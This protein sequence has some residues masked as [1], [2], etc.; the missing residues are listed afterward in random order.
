M[1]PV[2]VATPTNHDFGLVHC[3]STLSSVSTNK[4]TLRIKLGNISGAHAPW[5]LLHIPR[6]KKSKTRSAMDP[7][8]L[9]NFTNPEF[10]EKVNQSSSAALTHSLIPLRLSRSQHYARFRIHFPQYSTLLLQV[11]WLDDVTAFHFDRSSGMVR[12]GEESYMEV[13]FSPN[14]NGR[15]YCQFRL[16]VPFA[17]GAEQA[18]HEP[19]VTI[20][21]CGTGTFDESQDH[22]YDFHH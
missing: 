8:V 21:L 9:S 13:T 2:L 1:R 11:D 16:E 6:S 17:A 7:R 3:N 18:E 5:K 22:D 15:Y 19:L 12:A 10:D 4:Q 14:S 20:N